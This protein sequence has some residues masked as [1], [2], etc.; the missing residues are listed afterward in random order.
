MICG[1]ELVSARDV[2][3]TDGPSLDRDCSRTWLAIQQIDSPLELF[4]T[5]NSPS[6]YTWESLV[7]LNTVAV[8][9]PNVTSTAWPPLFPGVLFMC[10]DLTLKRIFTNQDPLIWRVNQVRFSSYSSLSLPPR[11]HRL[12]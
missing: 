10:P 3:R 6:Y 5:G 12:P 2:L 1:R 4:L 7:Y 8:A 11:R 9:L